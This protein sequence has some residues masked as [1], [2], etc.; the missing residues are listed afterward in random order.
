MAT[1]AEIDDDDDDDAVEGDVDWPNALSRDFA[2]ALDATW[3]KTRYS[4]F[5]EAVRELRAMEAAFVARA[6]DSEVDIREMR[7][8]I[9]GQLLKQTIEKN[10]P[11]EVCEAYWDDLLAIGF[12]CIEFKVNK[13]WFFADCCRQHGQVDRGLAVLESMVAELEQMR[14]VPDATKSLKRYCRDE[15]ATFGKLRSKLEAL[16]G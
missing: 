9:A 11:F 1:E 16:R 6:G 10:Q 12:I 3:L 2:M 7:Q 14:S 8:A 13:T 5:S 15:L 4:D